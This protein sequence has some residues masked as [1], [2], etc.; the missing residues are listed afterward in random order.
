MMSKED[1]GPLA[2]IAFP[3][4]FK[5][6][7]LGV[8]PSAANG[9]IRW[10]LVGENLWIHIVSEVK[11]GKRPLKEEKKESF[12]Y[13]RQEFNSVNNNGGKSFSSL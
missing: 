1:R 12:V 6:C 7:K 10:G 3:F 8:N 2:W 13:L 11:R 4:E 5:P 9:L